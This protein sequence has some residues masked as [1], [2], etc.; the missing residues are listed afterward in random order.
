[1]SIILDHRCSPPLPS[2]LEDPFFS[3]QQSRAIPCMSGRHRMEG[4]GILFHPPLYWSGRERDPQRSDCS[5]KIQVQLTL[6][7]V[8][9]GAARRSGSSWIGVLTCCP[10]LLHDLHACLHLCFLFFQSSSRSRHSIIALYLRRDIYWLTADLRGEW[11]EGQSCM[12]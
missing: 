1:M 4:S 10:S 5:C 3:A 7:K 8:A 2:R 9:S 11:T 12:R 6:L